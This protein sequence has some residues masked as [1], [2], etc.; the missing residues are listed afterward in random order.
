MRTRL[1]SIHAL[2]LG[3]CLLAGAAAAEDAPPIALRAEHFTVTPSTGPI[4]HVRVQN[5][6]K[7]DWQ[8]AVSIRVPEG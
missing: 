1:T 2:P 6:G 8:G 7:V 4:M 3:L 5:R